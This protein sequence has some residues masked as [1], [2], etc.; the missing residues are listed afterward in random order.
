MF[1]IKFDLK[2]NGEK[3]NLTYENKIETLQE[4]EATL[5]STVEELKKKLITR[6]FKINE[7]EE[8]LK[9]NNLS[10]VSGISMD[11]SKGNISSLSY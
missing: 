3:K 1:I 11:K 6:D 5:Q 9:D 2:I 4:S 7:L 8:K 10:F